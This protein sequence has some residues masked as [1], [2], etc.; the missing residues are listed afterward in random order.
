MKIGAFVPLMTHNANPT[1]LRTL[2]PALEEHGFESVWVP[3]HLIFPPR[4]VSRYPYSADGVPPVTVD[5]PLLD[6]L[7]ILAHLAAV[8]SRIRLGTN[9]YVLPLRHPIDD[10][11]SVTVG[12]VP[13]FHAVAGRKGQRLACM[14]VPSPE[15]TDPSAPS[16]HPP[17]EELLK[18]MR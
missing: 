13:C 16:G 15:S 9:I 10:P 12:D 18:A 17:V 11:L 3:E 7:L 4:F 1:F 5:M 2:G 14:I 8:T 6:P